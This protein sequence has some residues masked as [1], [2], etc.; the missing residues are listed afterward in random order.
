MAAR[1]SGGHFHLTAFRLRPGH[2]GLLRMPY[3]SD[4]VSGDVFG[5]L[6]SFPARGHRESMIDPRRGR[7][8]CRFATDAKSVETRQ[9]RSPAHNLCLWALFASGRNC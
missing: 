8:A 2:S 3:N 4:V 1:L 5:C 6:A 9:S 7:Y